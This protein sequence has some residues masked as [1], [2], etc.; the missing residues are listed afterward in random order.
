MANCRGETALSA[1][2]SRCTTSGQAL[3]LVASQLANF[4]YYSYVDF[5]EL[6]SLLARRLPF[7]LVKLYVASQP[8]RTHKVA[9]RDFTFCQNRRKPYKYYAFYLRKRTYVCQNRRGLSDSGS[10]YPN[11]TSK[12]PLSLN[13]ALSSCEPLNQLEP[14]SIPDG[15]ERKN[16]VTCYFIML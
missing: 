6:A 2:S 4:L 1:S 10:L 15:S 3:A 8:T 16:V 11:T 12:C 5:Y 7:Y 9:K 14:S 13:R